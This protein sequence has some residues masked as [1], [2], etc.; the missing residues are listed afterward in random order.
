MSRKILTDAD[1][2]GVIRKFAVEP[3]ESVFVNSW[4]ECVVSFRNERIVK[5]KMDT[6]FKIFLSIMYDLK[7]LERVTNVEKENLRNFIPDDNRHY[8]VF[9]FRSGDLFKSVSQSGTEIF[10]RLSS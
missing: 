3:V 9:G 7:T 1:L 4:G 8:Y 5:Q 10:T 2:E 6:Y